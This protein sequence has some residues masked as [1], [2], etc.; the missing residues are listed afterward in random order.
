MSFY[1]YRPTLCILWAGALYFWLVLPVARLMHLCTLSPVE[2][3]S[4]IF[5]R[6]VL[7]IILVYCLCLVQVYIVMLEPGVLL[8]VHFF[9]LW[10]FLGNS[11]CGVSSPCEIYFLILP[12]SDAMF[13]TSFGLI[14]SF[15]HYI[16]L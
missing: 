13:P 2:V 6:L 12:T 1:L 4:Y 3:W 7:F 9:R 15:R 14:L 11:G 8:L 16:V 10:L 5:A